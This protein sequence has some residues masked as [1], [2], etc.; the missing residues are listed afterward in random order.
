MSEPAAAVF[1]DYDQ[2]RL[3]LNYNQA[4]WAPN[5]EEII[6]W[7]RSASA[8]AHDRLPSRQLAYGPE[9]AE[10]IDLFPAPA[11]CAPLV[12][13]IHGGAWRSLDHRDSAFAAKAFVGAGLNFAVLDFASIPAVR[14]PEMVMQV[15]RGIGW[16]ARHAAELNCD[17]SR[18]I[19]LGHSS[20]AHLVAA[21]LTAD[22]PTRIEPGQVAAAICVSGAYDLEG[23]MLS[24]RGSY[25]QLGAADIAAYSPIRHIGALACPLLIAYGEAETDEYRRHAM[26]FHAALAA[27]GKAAALHFEAGQNH[28]EISRLLAQPD[29]A[30]FQAA[31][32]LAAQPDR[33]S[34]S[35]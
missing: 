15:Q 23:P 1:L 32:K 24:A 35:D 4:A 14:L 10:R 33:C 11:P 30:L 26:T 25:L 17:A 31:A 22:T 19:V 2:A 7:Y 34:Q 20:G 6:A 27:A 16:L 8:A 13:Y 29:S 9:P 12:V 3:D 28:F 18:L 21:A 5:A